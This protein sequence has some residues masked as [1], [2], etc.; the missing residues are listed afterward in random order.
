MEQEIK[1]FISYLHNVKKMS[2]N[3]EMSYNRDLA[4]LN[5]YMA[6]RGI[7]DVSKLSQKDLSDYIAYLTDNN[8]SPATVSRNIS[9][10]LID[11]MKNSQKE[12]DGL[13][14]IVERECRINIDAQTQIDAIVDR[15]EGIAEDIR[16]IDADEKEIRRYYCNFREPAAGGVDWAKDYPAEDID[17]LADMASEA[18]EETE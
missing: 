1:A 2:L 16:R 9:N 7:D 4:K 18:K 10:D 5:R 12:I 15:L 14:E 8:F 11:A 3:T 13:S 17:E 6:E